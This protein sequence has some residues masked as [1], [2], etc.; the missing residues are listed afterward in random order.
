MEKFVMISLPKHF[1]GPYKILLYSTLHFCHCAHWVR[2]VV[3]PA[4]SS[5]SLHGERDWCLG[6]GGSLTSP[7]APPTPHSCFGDVRSLPAIPVPVCGPIVHE[8]VQ[9]LLSPLALLVSP[10]LCSSKSQVF[11]ISCA[12]NFFYFSS[13][14]FTS[15]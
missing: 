1:E 14:K 11:T 15:S 3:Q 10:A 9:P 5:A 13:S 4:R 7:T 12:N 8:F 6:R 2:S